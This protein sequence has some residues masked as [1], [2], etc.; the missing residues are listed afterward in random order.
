MRGGFLLA[1]IRLIF[2]LIWITELG[3]CPSTPAS[4]N[5]VCIANDPTDK[6]RG[7]WRQVG[8]ENVF[9]FKIKCFSWKYST[10]SFTDLYPFPNYL[11]W[12]D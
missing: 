5:K 12:T 1:V 4:T 3:C 6:E 10:F 8:V 9:I 7:Q 11:R 2:I